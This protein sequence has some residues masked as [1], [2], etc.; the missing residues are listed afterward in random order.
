LGVQRTEATIQGPG[1]T[2]KVTKGA[3]HIIMKLVH[4]GHEI[5]STV[6]EKVQK[7]S[8]YNLATYNCLQ[9]VFSDNI[10]AV[11]PIDYTDHSFHTISGFHGF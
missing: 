9:L 8:Q 5:E 6:D 10:L 1:G 2:F 11:A 4:N 7:N 3:V